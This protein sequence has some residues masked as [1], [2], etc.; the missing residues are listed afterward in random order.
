MES[1][2]TK[3]LWSGKSGTIRQP[4]AWKAI[5]LPIELLPLKKIMLGYPSRPNLN[6]LPEF[7]WRQAGGADLIDPVPLIV[8]CIPGQ[9]HYL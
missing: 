9:N 5:A 8:D 1:A 7:Y 3:D 6:C 4:I 2:S